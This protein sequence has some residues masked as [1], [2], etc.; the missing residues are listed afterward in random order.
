[1]DFITYETTFEEYTENG[2]NTLFAFQ[3]M[4]AHHKVIASVARDFNAYHIDYK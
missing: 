3:I 2:S 1:M 4:D